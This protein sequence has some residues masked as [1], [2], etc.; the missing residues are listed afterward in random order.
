MREFRTPV[1]SQRSLISIIAVPCQTRLTHDRRIVARIFECS[2]TNARIGRI[3]G[4]FQSEGLEFLIYDQ[5]HFFRRPLLRFGHRYRDLKTI[6]FV[7]KRSENATFLP[8]SPNSITMELVRS[9]LVG[10]KRERRAKDHSTNRS[11]LWI[12]RIQ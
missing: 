9:L 5:T 12:A 3:Y 8:R 4:D 6:G 1:F 10:R 11:V 2:S 7:L